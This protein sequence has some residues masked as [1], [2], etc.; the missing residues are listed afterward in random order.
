MFIKMLLAFVVS[1]CLAG[2]A[3]YYGMPDFEGG[4]SV[5]QSTEQ[6]TQTTKPKNFLDKFLSKNH[7]LRNP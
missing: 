2:G 7:L 3:V 4:K 6:D 1:I 5:A